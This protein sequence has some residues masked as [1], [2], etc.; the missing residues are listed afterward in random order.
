MEKIDKSTS[1][2]FRRTIET[3]LEQLRIEHTKGEAII[4]DREEM[5]ERL[6]ELDAQ[7]PI[8]SGK[9]I[10]IRGAIQVLE[11]LLGLRED[12]E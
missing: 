5:R 1:T 12:S 2:P 3:R 9:M 4:A 10:R 11:E 8:L 6:R 7:A